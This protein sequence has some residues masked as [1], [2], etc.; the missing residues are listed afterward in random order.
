MPS[1]KGHQKDN[2]DKQEVVAYLGTATETNMYGAVAETVQR[3]TTK[4]E[5]MLEKASLDTTHNPTNQQK[6]FRQAK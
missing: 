2:V 6:T 4:K 1:L 5:R 3:F